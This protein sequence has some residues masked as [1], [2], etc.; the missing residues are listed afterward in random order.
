MKVLELGFQFPDMK[1]LNTKVLELGFQFPD[2]NFR[3][4][5]SKSI[6]PSFW[7]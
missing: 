4:S 2:M 6:N 1:V 5:V 3:I 7:K